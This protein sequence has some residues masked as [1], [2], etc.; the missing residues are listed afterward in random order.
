MFDVTNYDTFQNVT[1]PCYIAKYKGEVEDSYG[2]KTPIYDAPNEKPYEWNI[3]NASQSSETYAFGEKIINMKVALLKGIDRDEFIN[4]FSEFDLAYLDGATPD[5]E[6]V[7]G[8]NANYRIYAI[9]PQNVALLIY[10]E[11]R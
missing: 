4:Q 9:K 6:E 5:G 3:Q 8:D 11:K 1:S 10:F 2:N 7:I